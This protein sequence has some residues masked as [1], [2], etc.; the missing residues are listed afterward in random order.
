[1]QVY[2]RV[3]YC[4]INEIRRGPIF[5]NFLNSTGSSG[6]NFVYSL[7]FLIPTEGFLALW[8]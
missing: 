7:Y 1:M 8:F 5:V 6:R 4:G 2:A 3:I